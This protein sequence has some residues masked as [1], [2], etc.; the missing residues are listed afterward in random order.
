MY[1]SLSWRNIWRNK[2]RTFIVAASV[3]FAVLLATVMRSMQLGSYAYMIDSSAKLFT[4]YLQV[5]EKDY[6]DNRSPEKSFTLSR[7]ELTALQN[8]PHVRHVTPRLDAFALVSHDS[9][10]KVAQIIGIEPESENAFTG[11][12]KRLIAG[13][14][15]SARSGGAVIAEGLAKMLHLQP[16]DSLILYGQGFHGQIAAALLPVTGIARMPLNM[17]NNGMVFLSLSNAQEIFWMPGRITS[18]PVLIDDVVHLDHVLEQ[19]RQ[20]A[21]DQQ[22]VMPWD[23]MMPEL[24][25]N[26]EA[27]NAGGIIMLAI[28]YI[29][30]G[31]G[32]LGTIMM[33]VAERAREFSILISVG[34]RKG[35]LIFATMLETLMVSFL[36][37]IAGLTVSYP[38][39]WY[40]MR[41]PIHITGEAAKV[42][43]KLGIEAVFAFTDNMGIFTSQAEAILIIALIAVIYPY[44]FIRKLDPA[45]TLHG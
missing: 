28:L 20:I 37:A 38:I 27:D 3:F 45:K 42:Y 16:G 34:M 21:G 35:R 39:I 13:T 26:I 15:L 11:L 25:Q 17:M 41:S 6:W 29:V 30:I 14:Y 31:F 9:S 33:M 36:V 24:K 4:G 5:Q 8:I 23:E 22:R 44:L 19:A 7:Q 1:F 12:K 18:V 32:V 40:L 43:E 10:T 2:K